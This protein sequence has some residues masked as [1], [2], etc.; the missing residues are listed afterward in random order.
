MKKLYSI[1]PLL[2]LTILLV[3]QA[4][5]GV[6]IKNKLT[7]NANSFPKKSANGISFTE[8]KGQVHDQNNKARPD[9][10]FGGTDG[11]LVFHLK[12]NGISYQLSKI[13]SWKEVEDERTK[14]TRKQIDKSTIYRLDIEW[15]NANTNSK[16]LKGKAF[17]GFDNYYLENCPN[18]ALNVKSFDEITYQNIYSGIDLKWYQKEGHLKYDYL[19]AAGA[20]YKTIQ[21][22][23]NGAN[24]IKLN[25]KGELVIATPLGNIIEQSPLVVQNNKT[26]NAKWVIKNRIV[27][28]DIENLDPKQ[29]FVIDPAVRAWG[30]Y[31]GGTV[32]DQGGSCETDA[33][34]NVYMAGSTESSTGTV[35]ATT[36]SHQSTF[37]G[38]FDAFLV[39]FNSSGVRQWATYYGGIN[40]EYAGSCTT[41][42]VGNVYLVGFTSSTAGTVIAT[43]GSHQPTNLGGYEGFLAKFDPS[44]IRQWSTYYG[45]AL[46]DRIFNCSVDASGNIF[47]AGCSSSNSGTTIASAGAH[48]PANGGGALDCFL[49]KFNSSGVRQWGTYYGGSGDDNAGFCTIDASGNVYLVGYTASNIGTVIATVGSHQPTYGGGSYDGFLA[50]F[51]TNG[52]RQWGTYYGGINYDLAYACVT[53]TLGDVYVTGRT[54]SNIG[55]AIATI[56]SHQPLFGGADDGYLVKF[57]SSGVRQWGTYYGGIDTELSSVISSDASGNIFIGGYT[58]TSTGTSI[59]SVGSHQP[60]F[61]GGTR[62]AFMVKFDPLGVRQWGTYYGGANNDIAYGSAGDAIGNVY[63]AGYSSSNT[64]TVIATAGSH[65]SS[66]GGIED[67]FLVKFNDCSVPSNPSGS[68]QSICATNAATLS[69]TSGTATINW[70]ATPSSTT[71]LGTGTTYITPTLTAGSY[72]YYAEA[73]TC[74]TS[75]TRTAI[76]LTVNST[77]TISVN[78]GSICSGNSFTINPSGANTYTIQGGNT[79]VSPAINSSYTVVGISTAGCVSAG[80]STSNVTV[81]VSPT[82]SVNSGS[83]C[84][85]NSFTISPSGANSYTI[86]GGNYVVNPTSNASYTVVGTSSAGCISSLAATSSVIVNPLPTINATTNNTLICVGQSAI[87]TASGASTYTFNPSGIGSSISVSP[88]VTTNYTVTGTDAFGCANSVALTQSVSACTGIN[89]L[90]ENNKELKIY[91]N[92]SNGIIT[93]FGIEQNATISIYNTIGELIESTYTE[94]FTVTINLSEYSNGIFFIKIKNNNGEAIHKLIKQ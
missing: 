82:I 80:F 36:G 11:N 53:N 43:L 37:G 93:I 79:I 71:V 9:V 83:I 87:L 1:T 16:I 78:S 3:L 56:G 70:F 22:K 50:K 76:S 84:S 23:F 48:Q 72:T 44:G 64:G 12:N 77:P 55:T 66:F 90:F 54:Q 94:K 5:A 65:Q 75:V 49:A 2:F 14:I 85:G 25:N 92:P 63:F 4:N 21:L 8:N 57:N 51:N 73:F 45:G 34:G 41:D 18:G 29:P 91:P 59:A 47:I 17:E 26:L 42:A 69:A 40:E 68:N 89:S 24:S 31:Y 13:N 67:A 7:N 52:I 81:S 27:S 32:A 39:K 28:F 60:T 33:L 74:V 35:I 86:Q 6:T 38:N 88:T 58:A 61:G 19:V 30:T 62:D 20:N 46:Y 15:L 10:L